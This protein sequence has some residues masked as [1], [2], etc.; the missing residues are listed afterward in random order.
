[1]KR[2]SN[3]LPILISL[4]LVPSAFAQNITLA[5]PASPFARLATIRIGNIVSAAISLLL[6]I[7][8]VLAFIYLLSGGAMWILAGGDKDAIEKA[9]RRVTH[10]LIGLAIVFSVY[11]LA[12]IIRALFQVNLGVNINP[13]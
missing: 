7:S 8:G 2:L 5:N 12:F 1:M 4:V 3:F 10:S 9:R 11:A 6:G 13:I